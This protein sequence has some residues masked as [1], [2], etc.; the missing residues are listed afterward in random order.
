MQYNLIILQY[1]LNIAEPD[2]KDFSFY[3]QN[4]IPAIKHLKE[5]FPN[6]DI[7]IMSVSDKC[8]KRGG[9]F[10]TEPSIPLIIEAQKQISMET[11]CVF[12][13]LF[14]AMGGKT[15]TLQT[16]IILTSTLP[17]LKKSAHF[18]IIN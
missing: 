1:G 6:A 13:N 14:E 9:K 8:Y 2:T 16:K 10:V 12:W 18:F 11:G 7:L 15:I 5:C 4:L 17:G 3:I